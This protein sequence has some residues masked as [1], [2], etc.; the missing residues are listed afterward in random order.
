MSAT[1]DTE[2]IASSLK[3]FADKYLELLSDIRS[4]LE[5][6]KQSEK[7]KQDIQ[8]LSNIIAA[9]EAEKFEKAAEL[10]AESQL[11][12]L[13]YLHYRDN[14]KL[15]TDVNSLRTRY[16]NLGLQEPDRMHYL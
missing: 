11:D 14:I 4:G 2:H 7:F 6:E 5:K 12:R 8:K 3:N 13:F 15:H 10:L 16:I 9:L 1:I